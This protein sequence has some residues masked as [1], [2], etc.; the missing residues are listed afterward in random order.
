MEEVSA[1][2]SCLKNLKILDLRGIHNCA[3]IK[4]MYLTELPLLEDTVFS[5]HND[6]VCIFF[7]IKV[8]FFLMT[9]TTRTKNIELKKI[10]YI[11]NKQTHI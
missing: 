4:F 5:T 9:L 1:N 7:S 11:M 8:S 3:A 2:L 10:N 6:K